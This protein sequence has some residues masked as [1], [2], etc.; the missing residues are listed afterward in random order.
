M[1]ADVARL[2]EDLERSSRTISRLAKDRADLRGALEPLKTAILEA[3][4]FD[5]EWER[6]AE[7]AWPGERAPDA[8]PAP[9]KEPSKM[10]P[11]EKIE[12]ASSQLAQAYQCAMHAALSAPPDADEVGKAL[13]HARTGAAELEELLSDL[14]DL[15]VEE[16][17]DG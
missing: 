14:E 8:T 6:V 1:A 16:P 12:I 10:P 3:A 11:A 9:A 7:T 13:Q 2:R 15:E 17:S 5:T 4:D